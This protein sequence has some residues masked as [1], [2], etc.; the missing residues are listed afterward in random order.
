M[1][2]VF[3]CLGWDT[4][5]GRS[6]IL[7]LRQFR[8]L[9]SAASLWQKT[10]GKRLWT[11]SFIRELGPA[12]SIMD[13]GGFTALS[14]WSRYP[15]SL[16]E[17]LAAAGEL[18][19]HWI[20][21]RDWPCEPWGKIRA[22]VPERIERTVEADGEIVDAELPQGSE[23]LPVIQGWTVEDYVSCID[24]LK[25]AG[26]VRPKM[27]VGSCCARKSVREVL[28]IARAIRRELP[29]VALHYFGMKVLALREPGFKELADSIDTGAWQR[30]VPT[31]ERHDAYGNLRLQARSEERM[32]RFYRYRTLLKGTD[33]KALDS[34]AGNE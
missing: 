3:Y 6:P 32:D 27:A 23:P 31:N 7:G 1:T 29:G 4:M 33:Q 15:W 20:A 25:D 10:N 30:W 22:T 17:Y 16:P 14:G 24:R 18:K 9:V 11:P 13:S 8:I 26:I 28:P 2:D 5:S 34:F 12:D 21:A 19:L